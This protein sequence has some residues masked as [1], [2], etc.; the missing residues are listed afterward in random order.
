[1]YRV[2]AAPPITTTTNP[3]SQLTLQAKPC[4]HQRKTRNN[5]PGSLPPRHKP[6]CYGT[7]TANTL[8]VNQS[9][10]HLRTLHHWQRTQLSENSH[11]A[12]ACD[13]TGGYRPPNQ[14]SVHRRKWHVSPWL[15]HH[16][17]PNIKIARSLRHWHRKHLC[18]GCP[19]RIRQNYHMI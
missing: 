9:H 2:A 1:M 3:T 5:T 14:Q 11:G 7:S 8:R 15:I 12:F 6:S 16:R 4:T 17:Q 10:N 13:I 19:P 18:S